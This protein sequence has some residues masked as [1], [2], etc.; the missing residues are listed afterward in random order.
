[1]TAGKILHINA[2][3]NITGGKYQGQE[4]TVVSYKW[5]KEQ[6]LIRVQTGFFISD[7]THECIP[8]DRLEK[9]QHDE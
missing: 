2:R 9:V 3:V 8:S 4:G 7:Y 5:D 6:Y 1:M